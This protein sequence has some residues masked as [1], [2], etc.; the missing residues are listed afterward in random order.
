MRHSTVLRISCIGTTLGIAAILIGF[1]ALK[2]QV[3]KPAGTHFGQAVE[4]AAEVTLLTPKVRTSSSLDPGQ[5]EISVARILEQGHYTRQKLDSTKAQKILESYLRLLDPNRLYLMREDIDSFYGKHLPTLKN[6]ILQGDLTPAREIYAVYKRRVENRVAKN[7]IFLKRSLSFSSNETVTLNREGSA[8]PKDEAAADDLWKSWLRAQILQ[9]RLA[10]TSITKSFKQNRGNK[11]PSLSTTKRPTCNTSG[12]RCFTTS[13]Q[14]NS[15]FPS[16][17]LSHGLYLPK[18]AE[19][20]VVRRLDNILR[21]LKHEESFDVVAK[22]LSAISQ[23]YDPHSDYLSPQKME[24]FAIA[25]RLS[26]VGIGA[27][28][29]DTDGYT[30]VVDI[31]P[32]G[33]ADKDGRLK[34]NDC[35]VGVAQGNTPFEDMVNTNLER[36]VERIRGK[37]GTLVRLLVIPGDSPDSS[38]RQ[39]IDITRDEVRLKDQQAR[40]EVIDLKQPNGSITRVGWIM[41]PS[42]YADID[43]R[44]SNSCP[45]TTQDVSMLLRRLEKEGIQ[46]LIVDLRR[47][48]G[49]SLQEAINLTGFFIPRG[50]VLQVKDSMGRVSVSYCRGAGR[51]YEGPL[52]VLVNHLSASASEIF[53]AAL[54]DYGRAVIVGDSRTFSKGTVQTILDV[55]RFMPFFSLAAADAGSLKLTIQK[56]YRIKGGSTQLK[57]VESDI[58]LPS[59]LDHPKIGETALPNALP[60]DEVPPVPFRRFPG[61]LFLD[62]LRKR[63]SARV[64]LDPEFVYIREEMV[65][66]HRRLSEN[67]VSLNEET[68]K[69]EI[70]ESR[71]QKIRLEREL[72]LRGPGIRMKGYSVALDN[73][74]HPQLKPIQYDKKSRETKRNPDLLDGKVTFP[75]KLREDPIKTETLRIAQDLIHL[76]SGVRKSQPLM[77]H[78]QFCDGSA[79]S[80]GFKLQFHLHVSKQTACSL[81]NGSWG[82]VQLYSYSY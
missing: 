16:K 9:E 53:A 6:S 13:P 74:R 63:S 7:K 72:A 50:P 22:F 64:T 32:G 67:T 43:S 23:S 69:A 68:R 19:E 51:V 14:V 3:K 45:N 81:Q 20:I 62:Q 82:K 56:F 8:W 70:E 35:I 55:G 42:F 25:M 29:Q 11:V 75:S 4:A 28:L 10:G 39:L 58:V 31:I 12:N 47:N 59:L 15:C 80:D 36:V 77:S 21:T 52:V 17:G 38:K 37:K 54:Q 40:A 61:N 5:V 66:V 65:R 18:T 46:G 78:H 79:Y 26:L 33:P 41:L 34:V 2:G 30:R 49:G 76:S 60:Y 71:T 1:I 57:G 27:V 24:N 73:I 44:V 48:G